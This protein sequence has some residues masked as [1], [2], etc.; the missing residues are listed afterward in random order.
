M[1]VNDPLLDKLRSEIARDLR[2]VRPLRPAWL[3]ALI[4][5]PWSLLGL[6]ILSSVFSPRWGVS[7]LTW[8]VA[9]TQVFVSYILLWMALREAEPGRGP[10]AFA[11]ATAAVAALG[12]PLG[13]Y[14]LIH[15]LHAR[16]LPVAREWSVGMECISV[17]MAIGLPAMAIGLWLAHRGL[18]LRPAAAGA[19]AGLAAGVGALGVWTLFCPFTSPGHVLRSHFGPLVVLG[20]LGLG[21]AAAVVY[22]RRRSR[23]RL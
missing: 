21:L 10:S 4:L 8:V 5:L 22:F 15:S 3:R 1:T 13:V 2:P 20:L 16:P 23:E 6:A 14:L 12:V 19:F 17:E 11:L 9:G 18:P 7:A